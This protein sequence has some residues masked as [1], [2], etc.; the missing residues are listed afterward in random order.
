[1]YAVE[2]RQSFDKLRGKQSAK[3]QMQ[4]EAEAGQI[5]VV[6]PNEVYWLAGVCSRTRHDEIP[7]RISRAQLLSCG[8]LICQKVCKQTHGLQISPNDGLGEMHLPSRT[9]WADA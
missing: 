1:M 5:R 2:R 4:W 6:E 3:R 8:L 9:R 7:L